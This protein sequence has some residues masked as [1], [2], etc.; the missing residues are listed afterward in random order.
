ML[1]FNLQTALYQKSE[2]TPKGDQFA[3]YILTNRLFYEIIYQPL[4]NKRNGEI[5]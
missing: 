2:N 3:L 1:F 5:K 4:Y